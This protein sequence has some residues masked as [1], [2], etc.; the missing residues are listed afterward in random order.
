MTKHK[1]KKEIPPP[2]DSTASWEDQAAYFEKYG[3]DELEAAGHLQPLTEED[4]QFVDEVK[5]EAGKR[6]SARKERGQ[7][8][9]A[10]STEQLNRFNKYANRKHIPPSTLA[11]AWILERL[12]QEAKEA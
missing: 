11:K 9:L 5:T 8:N 6:V 7:L 3:M 1:E 10:F 12:D 4:Q 2:P